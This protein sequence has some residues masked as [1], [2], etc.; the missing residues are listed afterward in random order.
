MKG[1]IV[2]YYDNQEIQ[3]FDTLWDAYKGY[4]NI[5][6]TDLRNKIHVETKLYEWTFEYEKDDM[7]YVQ[8]IKF[9]V[10]KNK[11]YWKFI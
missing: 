5:R 9:Y 8:P 1:K 11:M 10:R 4:K 7:L 6:K 2:L 3:R